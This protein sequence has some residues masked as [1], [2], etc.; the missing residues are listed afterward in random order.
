[1][2][3]GL[4]QQARS[5]IQSLQGHLDDLEDLLTQKRTKFND[6]R[7]KHLLLACAIPFQSMER[8]Q[9]ELQAMHKLHIKKKKADPKTDPNPDAGVAE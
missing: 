6:A 1:M 7:I 4:V 5:G 3:L 9:K 2:M 8:L